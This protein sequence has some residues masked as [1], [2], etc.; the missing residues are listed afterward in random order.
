MLFKKMERFFSEG[1]RMSK[2]ACRFISLNRFAVFL[3]V[4]DETHSFWQT[5]DM[6]VDS[7]EMCRSKA[8]YLYVPDL[9]HPRF[10]TSTLVS[11]R[12][13]VCFTTAEKPNVHVEL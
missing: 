12:L 11:S 2:C 7:G 5:A 6:T 8:F 13:F 4:S 10:T 9:S 1:Q 3:F